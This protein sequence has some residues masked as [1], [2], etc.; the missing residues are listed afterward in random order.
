MGTGSHNFITKNDKNQ[1]GLA[2]NA[3][4]KLRSSY[5]LQDHD[6]NLSKSSGVDAIMG[7]FESDSLSKLSL[8]SPNFRPV[9]D[10]NSQL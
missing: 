4:S 8:S 9:I 3:E 5:K 1:K 6:M 10:Q 2:T 7:K